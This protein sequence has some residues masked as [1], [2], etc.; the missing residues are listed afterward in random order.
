MPPS[1]G[2]VFE[3]D[4]IAPRIQLD[5]QAKLLAGQDQLLKFHGAQAAKYRLQA[6]EFR[7]ECKDPAELHCARHDRQSREVSIQAAQI[8]WDQQQE[9]DMTGPLDTRLEH[10]GALYGDPTIRIGQG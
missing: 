1:R 9:L 8:R 3:L 10:H 4:C 5:R 7:R 6:Q 2:L